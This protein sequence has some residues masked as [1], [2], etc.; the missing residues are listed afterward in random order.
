MC[1][2]AKRKRHERYRNMRLLAYKQMSRKAGKSKSMPC[3]ACSRGFTCERLNSSLISLSSARLMISTQYPT[4]VESQ[5]VAIPTDERPASSEELQIFHRL[6]TISA[7]KSA[8]CTYLYVFHTPKNVPQFHH[9]GGTQTPNLT[10]S[11]QKLFVRRTTH[12]LQKPDTQHNH[13]RTCTESF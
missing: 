6:H 11:L 10:S 4:F 13:L 7:S 8:A 9:Y 5:S 2:L 12:P 3:Q 1:S